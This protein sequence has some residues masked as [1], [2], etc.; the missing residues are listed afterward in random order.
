MLNIYKIQC[1]PVLACLNRDSANRITQSPN[2]Y[3]Y[4]IYFLGC[5]IQ[6]SFLQEGYSLSLENSKIYKNFIHIPI[7]NWKMSTLKE[8]SK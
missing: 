7:N 6:M 2:L 4:L 3:L 1:D 5:L 8:S